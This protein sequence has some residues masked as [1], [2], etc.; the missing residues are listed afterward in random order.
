MKRRDF[1]HKTSH[2]AAVSGIMSALPGSLKSNLGLHQL[3]SSAVETDHVLVLIF[4]N[5]GNDGLN[6]V[7]PV[8]MMS[9]LN[10]LRPHVVLPE[11]RLLGLTGVDNLALHPALEY[12]REMYDEGKLKIVQNVGYPQP[13]FSH[14]RSADIWMSASDS[15]EY[16][17]SGWAGRYLDFEYPGYPIDYP[18][19]DVPYPLAV[20]QGYGASL[21]FQ[22]PV[23][24][25]AVS[26]INPESYYE[27]IGAEERPVPNHPAGDKLKHIRLTQNQ[28]L[29][30]GEEIKKSALNAGAQGNY[31]DS[32][33]AQQL[34]IVAQL[35]SG[36]MGTRLYLVELGGFDTHDAQ[37]IDNNRTEGEH[38]AL[39]RTLNDATKAFMADLEGLGIAD[40]VMG[41]T[42]SEF[43][44]RIVSNASG[45]TDHG[46]AAPLFVFGNKVQGGILGENPLLNAQMT[47]ED[48][49]PHE[50]DFREVY[51]SM[52]HQ[53]LCVEKPDIDNI[54][55]QRFGT[56]PLADGSECFLSTSTR[57][58]TQNAG[59]VLIQVHPNP[60]NGVAQIDYISEGEK[61]RIDWLDGHGRAIE[62]IFYGY[63][64]A[65]KQRITVPT[66]HLPAGQYICRIRTS[67]YVQ[68]RTLIKK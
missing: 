5:G 34:K 12:Y 32:E 14:F 13:N 44:R 28:S 20:E 35:I 53:W 33:L 22:G 18:N 24:H 1:L 26:V 6:T 54:L 8:N 23:S 48:N 38:A 61:V 7:V 49:L 29:A 9:E 50:F 11:N 64:P 62:Q 60:L 31:P 43:G 68:G 47:Y 25:M 16:I 66:H 51:S 67:K 37:V 65:G 39:L 46:T 15:D 17:N 52:L 4:L 27:L 40:R 10:T 57:N 19:T 56:L 42:F 58:K 45:G 59:K 2:A 30:Y 3:L 36:G 21:L 63:A 41:M 55:G